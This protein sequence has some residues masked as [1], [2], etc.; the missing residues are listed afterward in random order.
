MFSKEDEMI[1]K[2]LEAYKQNKEFN[3]DFLML[4]LKDVDGIRLQRIWDD[5]PT[6][7]K[8]QYSYYIRLPCY[9]HYNLPGNTHIDGPP[10][11]RYR[12]CHRPS[13][14]SNEYTNN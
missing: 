12:C 2:V 3:Y 4:L 14:N 1:N 5:L 7:L 8:E 10:P 13:T 9:K 11:P 6:S